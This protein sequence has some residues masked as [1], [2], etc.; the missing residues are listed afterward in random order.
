MKH[1]LWM[2]LI[3]CAL[4]L[5]A[6]GCEKKTTLA[7]SDEP[8][9]ENIQPAAQPVVAAADS[10]ENLGLKIGSSYV[11]TLKQV[12]T[13]LRDK[14]AP[15]DALSMLTDMKNWTIDLMVGL[16]KE[17]AALSE[18]DR[19]VVD[20]VLGNKITSVSPELFKEY[21]DGQAYYKDQADL[22]ALIADFNIITQY[23]NFDLLKTQ[24]PQEAER[25]G[26][27]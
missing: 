23:A 8:I 16:G 10:A 15:E 19:A 1:Q 11:E 27:Q 13:I 12:V 22:F 20:R 26:I 14:P 18:E 9:A 25:L 5:S 3:G 24:H 17:R 4:V 2:L 6:A 7:S 21:Q